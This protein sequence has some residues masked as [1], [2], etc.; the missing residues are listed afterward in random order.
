MPPI[1]L[2]FFF[3]GLVVA[4][5]ITIETTTGNW[6]STTS[7]DFSN[8]SATVTPLDV[9]TD[10]TITTSY[11]V[12]NTTEGNSTIL[13]STTVQ[14]GG[15]SSKSGK[16]TPPPITTPKPTTSVTTTNKK[17][18]DKETTA[19]PAKSTA[20]DST[21]III[22][23]VII[24]VALGFGV[25]CFLRNRRRRNSVN[26]T[27]RPDE[28][29]I[30]LNSVEPIDAVP[31]NGLQTFESPETTKEP[32]EPEAKLEVQEEQKAEAGKS[33]VDPS[34]ESAAPVPTPDSSEDKPKEDVV[35]QSPPAPVEPSVEE[36]TD[37]EGAVSNKTSVES[38]KGTNEN[39][40]NNA[41][42]SQT[43]DAQRSINFWDVPLDCPV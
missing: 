22:L 2:F 17:N 27:S 9:T 8:Y 40:S 34:A 21:G 32:E 36:K 1:G 14:N 39:N 43:R 4:P 37:D 15:G 26:F 30:P 23:V 13:P 11:T 6:L 3:L 35:E 42:F 24:L 41:A 16:E 18:K 28:T 31:Q 29:N 33:V 5:D 12:M 20:G 38:L 19:K 7:N 25:A 10:V